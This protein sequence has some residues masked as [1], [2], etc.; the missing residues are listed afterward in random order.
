MN[1]KVILTSSEI[2]M[3]FLVVFVRRSAYK[4]PH[5]YP[6]Q[7]IL[8]H[9]YAQNMQIRKTAERSMAAYNVIVVTYWQSLLQSRLSDSV[10]RYNE[11][12]RYRLHRN[13]AKIA[14]SGSNLPD[15]CPARRFSTYKLSGTP[16]KK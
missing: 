1:K 6:V 4:N 8:P 11:P 16:L 14:F 10:E 15:R 5:P 3:L 7:R 2:T 9:G 12:P 13:F